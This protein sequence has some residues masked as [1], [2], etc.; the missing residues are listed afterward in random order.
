MNIQRKNSAHHFR[1]Q[2][3]CEQTADKAP[4]LCTCGKSVK[5]GTHLYHTYVYLATVPSSV[6]LWGAWQA[7]IE[8]G[9][10]HCSY[11]CK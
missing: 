8:N 4:L 3:E 5:L 10:N 9:C 7:F 1:M 11:L 6:P 2:G